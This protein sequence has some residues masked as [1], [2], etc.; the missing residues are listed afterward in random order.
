MAVIMLIDRLIPS[1]LTVS[2]L[3]YVYLLYNACRVIIAKNI[4][5]DV[6]LLTKGQ[7]ALLKRLSKEPVFYKDIDK[8][9]KGIGRFLKEQKFIDYIYDASDT[10]C[11]IGWKIN[12]AGKA[13]LA[14]IDVSNSKEKRSEIRAWITLAI[15][16]LAFI[17][18]VLSLSWQIYSWQL[19]EEQ[20][21]MEATTVVHASSYIR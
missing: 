7:Y 19:T 12:E 20:K 13:E 5:K 16:V 18:S 8:E 9:T 3:F 11:D 2:G 15:A 1:P 21:P 17:L 10:P 4:A 14:K 6:F